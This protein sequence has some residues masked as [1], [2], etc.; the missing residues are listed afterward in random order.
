M[1]VEK[2]GIIYI[3]NDKGCK[4]SEEGVY[5]CVEKGGRILHK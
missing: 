5:M 2:G 3:S 1:C 4:R